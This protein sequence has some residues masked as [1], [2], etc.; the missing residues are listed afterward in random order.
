MLSNALSMSIRMFTVTL[1]CLHYD[2]PGCGDDAFTPSSPFYPPFCFFHLRTLCMDGWS[3][4]RFFIDA[5]ALSFATLSYHLVTV[6]PTASFRP[7]EGSYLLLAIYEE[8]GWMF[9]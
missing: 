4:T 1:L 6:G 7:S 2:G 5:L 8:N 3:P 9:V